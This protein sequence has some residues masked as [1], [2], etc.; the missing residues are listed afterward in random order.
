[1][2]V[3]VRLCE[4]RG[5]GR[6]LVVMKRW[7]I[8]ATLPLNSFHLSS[9][10]PLCVHVCVCVCVCV[11]VR[12]SQS[13]NRYSS[14]INRQLVCSVF[15]RQIKQE[16]VLGLISAFLYSA[17]IKI[18]SILSKSFKITHLLSTV[19]APTEASPNL[20]VQLPPYQ[21]LSVGCRSFVFGLYGYF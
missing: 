4:A 12:L 16:N 15:Q 14:D 17:N 9:S 2:C 5:G 10:C 7:N 8:N 21:I 6:A 11:C 18:S 3:W 13:M 19:N 20:S 1:V